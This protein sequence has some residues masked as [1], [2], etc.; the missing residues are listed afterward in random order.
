ML[1]K[2]DV[3]FGRTNELTSDVAWSITFLWIAHLVVFWGAEAEAQNGVPAKANR[4]IEV[5][6]PPGRE[7]L[8]PHHTY[9]EPG[10]QQVL[11]LAYS[12]PGQDDTYESAAFPKIWYQVSSNGGKTFDALRPLVQKGADY[13]QLHPIQTIYIPK[14]GFVPSTQPPLRASN[15]EIMVPFYFW[16]LDEKGERFD[17]RG[18]Y[19]F[20]D[21]GVLIGR[22]KNDGWDLEW[23]LS[24]SVYLD[25]ETQSTRGAMEP[26]VVELS[27]PGHFLMVMRA[28][29]EGRPDLPEL[30]ARKWKSLS[31][32]YCRTWSA[33]TVFT[34]ANGEKFF[35]PSSCCDLRRNSKTGKLYWFGNICPNNTE[36]TDGNSPRYPL[37]V[38][39]VDEKE[40]ALLKSTVRV[41]DTRDPTTDTSKVQLSNFDL[42][43]DRKSGEFVITLRRLDGGKLAAGENFDARRWPRMRY[44]VGVR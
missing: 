29:N 25:S 12:V 15:G 36:R 43:E 17:A 38:G 26:A 28:S 42:K 21:S 31:T 6:Y 22:W 2:A 37:V 24:E 14:N 16:P 33:P 32:N 10:T 9:R 18:A 1:I 4:T 5:P 34:Y 39:E 3:S 11:R 40:L 20:S 8:F 41:I 30:S 7:N 19:T 35:S 13:D 23:D 27:K 44:V